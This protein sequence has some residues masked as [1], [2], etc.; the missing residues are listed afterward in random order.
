MCK[1]YLFAVTSSFP[2]NESEMLNRSLRRSWKHIFHS[3]SPLLR[4]S[5]L[6]ALSRSFLSF[7]PTVI[8]SSK[9]PHFALSKK[10]SK[11]ADPRCRSSCLLFSLSLP[12]WA[13]S[14][15]HLRVLLSAS[16]LLSVIRMQTALLAGFPYFP[17]CAVPAL[18]NLPT[19]K[20][21]CMNP[22]SSTF[23]LSPLRASVL[24]DVD[25]VVSQTTTTTAPGSTTSRSAPVP[26]GQLA[27]SF[28]LSSFRSFFTFNCEGSDWI[29]F[30]CGS[31][32]R[33]VTVSA[34][35][36][37]ALLRCSMT[38]ALTACSAL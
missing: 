32:H 14:S 7:G 34:S 22:Q 4:L 1:A 3:F 31:V 24:S 16:R 26:V 21:P 9:K 15:P 30:P 2:R 37:M 8:S 20:W 27:P 6:R 13:S 36:V 12:S 5:S 10:L 18:T 23:T 28:G 25:I 19:L 17:R 29:H 35:L 38:P 33:L 11:T